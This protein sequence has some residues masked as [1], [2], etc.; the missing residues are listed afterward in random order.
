MTYSPQVVEMSRPFPSKYISDDGRGNDYVRH[1]IVLQRLIQIFGRPPK[2]EVLRELY[3]AEK[4]TGVVMRLTV[5]GFDPVE[6][7]GEA[8]N[9]QSKTNGARAKDACSDAIKR[10]AMRLGLGLHLWSQQNYFLHEVL[11]RDSAGS[12]TTPTVNAEPSAAPVAPQP[13]MSAATSAEEEAG[14]SPVP[15][16]PGPSFSSW[17][18]LIEMFGRDV[19]W[20][21]AKQVAKDLKDGLVPIRVEMLPKCSPRV[22]AA[23]AEVLAQKAERQPQSL[24]AGA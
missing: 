5:P 14:G 12:V 21:T 20:Q 7:A 6:E 13:E 19:V 11:T 15:E 4:L 18:E 2:I 24:P 9:P 17:D 16:E 22:Y 3:D 23:T 10:C 1:D 8:D